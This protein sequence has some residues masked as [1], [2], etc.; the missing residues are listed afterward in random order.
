MTDHAAAQRAGEASIG[1]AA[2]LFRRATEEADQTGN[3]FVSPLS[4]ATALAL[5]LEG[6]QGDTAA[7]I[8]KALGFALDHDAHTLHCDVA[9]LMH[10]VPFPRLLELVLKL[11]L[12]LSL[13]T[14]TAE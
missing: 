7:Q 14:N 6:A 9:A 12:I 4:V 5:A 3:V 11:V 1:F 10:A 13:L 8:Q 2:E